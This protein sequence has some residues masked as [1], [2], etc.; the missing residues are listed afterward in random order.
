MGRDFGQ[1]K[2]YSEQTA[3]EIDDEIKAIIDRCYEQGKKALS[4]N[5]DLIRAVT[6]ELLEKETLDEK[7]VAAIIERTKALRA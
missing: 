7:E 1:T 6:G 5:I 3:R 2:N 4:E